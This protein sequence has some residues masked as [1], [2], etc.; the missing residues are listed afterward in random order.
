[1]DKKLIS[2]NLE[3][4]MSPYKK[5]MEIEF[6]K[7]IMGAPLFLPAYE[8]AALFLDIEKEFSINLDSVIPSL[9]SFS[10][11]AIVDRVL[12]E[13]NELAKRKSCNSK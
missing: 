9:Y 7:D 2:E 3:R 1:M 10:F 6:D 5:D 4:I 12:L 13:H 11:N 8:M